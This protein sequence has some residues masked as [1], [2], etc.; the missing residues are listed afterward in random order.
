MRSAV[1]S[2]CVARRCPTDSQ[3]GPRARAGVS[4]AAARAVARWIRTTLVRDWPSAPRRAGGAAL[5]L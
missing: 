1:A 2:A 4:G 3:A 5:I